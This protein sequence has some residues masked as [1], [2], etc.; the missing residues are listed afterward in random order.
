M[1]IQATGA[2]LKLQPWDGNVFVASLMPIGRF[3]P[4]VDL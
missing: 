4:I 2:K 3:G 1:E